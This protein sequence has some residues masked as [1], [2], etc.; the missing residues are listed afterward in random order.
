MRKSRDDPRFRPAA[1]VWRKLAPRWL[2]ILSDDETP[3][4]AA[5]VH[6]ITRQPMHERLKQ[7]RDLGE[8]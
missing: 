4:L 7:S 5:V 2:Q 3:E 1:T 8:K 6:R